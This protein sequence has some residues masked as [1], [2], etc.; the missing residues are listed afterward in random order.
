M[1]ETFFPLLGGTAVQ[2]RVFT[3]ADE[4]QAVAVLSDSGR[5]R[6]VPDDPAPVGK[7]VRERSTD[8]VHRHRRAAGDVHGHRTRPAGFLG[9]SLACSTERGAA[10]G[11]TNA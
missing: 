11:L 6:I 9:A 1:S 8:V 7:V 4:R 2:G 3:P 10:T 5:R